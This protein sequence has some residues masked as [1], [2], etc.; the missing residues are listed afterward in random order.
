MRP[1]PEPM[2]GT[3]SR[4]SR[5]TDE[6]RPIPRLTGDGYAADP[7]GQPGWYEREQAAA[8]RRGAASHPA[9]PVDPAEPNRVASGQHRRLLAAASSQDDLPGPSRRELARLIRQVR[10]LVITP[11]LLAVGW[12]GT[13]LV[14]WLIR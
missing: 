8:V 4:R 1:L 9:W 5:S 3:G 2:D 7:S 12:L 13:E 6:T 10:V 14:T 11:Y